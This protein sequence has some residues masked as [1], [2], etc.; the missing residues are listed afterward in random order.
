MNRE[1]IINDIA[2]KTT[3]A[4]IEYY[5]TMFKSPR[6]IDMGDIT[7][8]FESGAEWDREYIINKTIEYLTLKLYTGHD[9][10]NDSVVVSDR[11]NSVEDF[12]SNYLDF[13]KH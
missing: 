9:D 13:I 8:A 2:Y 3:D 1:D 11:C 12:I 5:N 6:K 4:A 10:W 7:D